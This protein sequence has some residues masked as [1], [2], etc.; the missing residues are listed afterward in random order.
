M[1]FN[2][3]LPMPPIRLST[4]FG[5]RGLTTFKRQVMPDGSSRDYDW[6]ITI[7]IRSDMPESFFDD[8]L[9]HEMIHYYISYNGLTDDGP[10]G[11]LFSRMMDS[12][13][14]EYSLHIEK[15]GDVSEDMLLQE[16][17]RQRFVCTIELKDGSFGFLVAA[18]NKLF[19]LWDILAQPGVP[20]KITWYA[21]FHPFWSH[22][23]IAVS[24][25][26]LPISVEDLDHYLKGS[27][28]LEKD[29][30]RIKPIETL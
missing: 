19:E 2:K 13:N 5:R 17:P 16:K 24:P 4:A 9:V 12:I 11:T 23:P 7:S 28:V 10:H 8:V 25:R 21:S 18:N 14:T 29:G 26:F 3:A 27:A 1:I 30:N 20:E 15:E 22:C 6:V